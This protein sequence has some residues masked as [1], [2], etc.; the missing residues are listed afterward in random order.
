MH[1]A[2]LAQGRLYTQILIVTLIIRASSSAAPLA[3]YEHKYISS[4]SL[5]FSPSKTPISP[6]IT[7]RSRYGV[8]FIGAGFVLIG[9]RSWGFVLRR[10]G[11]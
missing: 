9:S 3:G 2:T 4:E 8:V 11:L 6:S 7:R 1:T 10:K 5:I